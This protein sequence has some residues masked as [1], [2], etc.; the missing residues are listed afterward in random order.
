MPKFNVITCNAYEITKIT[1]YRKSKDDRSTM[2]NNGV[3]LKGESMYFF[4]S[5]D[6]NHVQASRAYFRVIKKILD[7]HY[8]AFKVSLFKC[9]GIDINTSVEIDELGFTRVDI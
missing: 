5:K 6:N 7:I 4:I 9:K 8:I 3:M 2:Q 1:F